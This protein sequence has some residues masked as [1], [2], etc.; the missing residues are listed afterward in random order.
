ME[1]QNRLKRA[2][3]SV[4]LRTTMTNSVARSEGGV[5]RK[6]NIFLVTA[7]QG[8]AIVNVLS[9]FQ[10]APKFLMMLVVRSNAPV[11]LC[12]ASISTAIRSAYWVHEKRYTVELPDL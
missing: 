7:T 8:P 5:S 4:P 9:C 3:S 12:F 1:K 6:S 2:E 10:T 11:S